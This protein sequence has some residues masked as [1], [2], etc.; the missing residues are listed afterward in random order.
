MTPLPAELENLAGEILLGPA[1]HLEVRFEALCG[2]HEPWRAALRKLRLD[3]ERAA[4]M[5][6][7]A[8]SASVPGIPETIGSYRVLRIVGEGAF[9]VVFLAEQAVPIRRQVAV[10]L[11]HTAAWSPTAVA[12]FL[13][14]REILSRMSHPAIARIFD[15]GLDEHGRPWMAMEYIAGE[16]LTRHAD[17]RDLALAARIG[18]FLGACDGVHHAHQ[19]GVIH[20]DLKPQNVLVSEVDG[21]AQAKVIDFGLAKVFGDE[22]LQTMFTHAG[23]VLGTPAYMSPE[24]IRGDGHA[25][26]TRTDVYALGVILYELLTGTLPVR[27]ED[28]RALPLAQLQRLIGEV[29]P[30]LA[31]QRAESA[32]R[33]WARN[34]RGDLDWILR[35]AMGKGVEDRYA[36]VAEFAADLKRHLAHEPVAAGPPSTS[37]LVRK[38]VR[39]HRGSVVAGALLMASLLAGLAVS[40]VLYRQASA[41]AAA[42]EAR[43]RDFWRLA[44]TVELDELIAAAATLWPSSPDRLADHETWLRRADA[45][46]GRRGEHEVALRELAAE[47]DAAGRSLAERQG[48]DFLA[49]HLQ[50]HLRALDGF[51]APGGLLEQVRSRTE[52]ARTVVVRS[53]DAQRAAWD[54]AIAAVAGSPSYGGLVLEPIR[55]LVPL[56]ADPDSGLEEFAHLQS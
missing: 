32:R 48:A 38:F 23:V 10:K 42:A 44:D 1:E 46:C 27:Q 13:N 47:A 3:F 55:G 5:F 30:P 40:G 31:S 19:R 16:S 35:K 39:R 2:G 52:F 53:I 14:E 25:A 41:S 24:Q 51:A 12:R 21:V 8:E 29:D 20:R 34:L 6:S 17:G 50:Q 15:A 9:G 7:G 37:Y 56:G 45:L 22:P 36:S 28:C 11:L 33:P 49:G 18:L 26:D 43:L 4:R 54:R